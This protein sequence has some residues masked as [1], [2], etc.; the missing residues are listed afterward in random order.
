[1]KV[2]RDKNNN[3]MNGEVSSD[4][5]SSKSKSNQSEPDPIAACYA[6]RSL[7]TRSTATNNVGILLVQ[8]W[9]VSC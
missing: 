2:Y 8:F 4:S 3:R 6:S 5:N 9:F 7:P 1:M